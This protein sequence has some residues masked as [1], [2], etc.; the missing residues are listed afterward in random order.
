MGLQDAWKIRHLDDEPLYCEAPHDEADILYAGS[1]DEH[2]DSPDARKLRIEQA[3][4][5]FLQGH[6][7]VLLTTVLRGPFEGPDSKGWVNP[8]QSRKRK[9]PAAST[10][11]PSPAPVPE[12]TTDFELPSTEALETRSTTSCHLPSPRSLDQ[13]DVTP[14]AFLEDEE[15]E[16]V[17]SWRSNTQS[18]SNIQDEAW[19]FDA[20]LS[21][22][23]RQHRRKRR[24]AGSEWLKRDDKKRRKTNDDA[25]NTR[26]ALVPVRRSTRSPRRHLSDSK[27]QSQQN[28]EDDIAEDDTASLEGSEIGSELPLKALQAVSTRIS[29]KM[30]PHVIDKRVDASQEMPAPLSTPV[31]T[32]QSSRKSKMTPKNTTKES[33]PR[34]SNMS[35]IHQKVGGDVEVKS[36]FETQQDES[37]MF[38]A[39]PRSHALNIED[40]SPIR[41]MSFGRASSPASTVSSEMDSHCEIMDL[42]GDTCMADDTKATS[43]ESSAESKGDHEEALENDAE[44]ATEHEPESGLQTDESQP[45]VSGESSVP[46]LVANASNAAAPTDVEEPQN[47]ER[48]K[49]EFVVEP[50]ID[51]SS[52]ESAVVSHSASLE[53][54][55]KDSTNAIGRIPLSSISTNQHLQLAQPITQPQAPHDNAISMTFSQS[56]WSKLSQVTTNSPCSVSKTGEA[57]QQSGNVESCLRRGSVSQ[58]TPATSPTAGDPTTSTTEHEPSYQHKDTPLRSQD[59][60]RV[61]EILS[62]HD[63]PAVPTSQQTPWKMDMPAMSPLKHPQP[64]PEDDDQSFL[65]PECQSPWAPSLEM[66]SKAAPE[67]VKSAFFNAARPVS[68]SSLSPS[69]FTIPFTPADK[70]VSEAQQP[71]DAEAATSSSPEPIFPIKSFKNFMSPSPER[72]RRRPNMISLS[73]GNLPSTQNLIAATTDNPWHSVPKSSKRVRWAPLLHEDDG[74]EG[75]CPQ[76]PTGPKASS[77]P[78]E[79][80]VVDLP[81]G[82][83]DQFQRHFRVVSQRKNLRHHLLPSASQ[84]MLKSPSPMAMA[85]AFVA[86]DS[87]RAPQGPDAVVSVDTTPVT[88]N[89]ESQESAMDDVDDV[90]RNLN[91]FIEMVDIETDLARAKDEEQENKRRRQQQSQS[92]RGA[93]AN[94]LNLDGMMDA[95]VWN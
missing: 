76:T 92:L 41:R 85:E 90:L 89:A 93:F 75:G 60:L 8:W 38:R 21:Q 94:G 28:Q 95:G 42:D 19:S 56:P 86:A 44:A 61:E 88:N 45:E 20:S 70:R 69:I 65:R 34:S 43:P 12:P 82:N 11:G 64:L 87:F 13:V 27:S 50:V 37:F 53:E 91:E 29:H 39:R 73:D 23:Q 66:M 33:G 48:T 16:R 1:D 63:S 7:P 40:L 72:P 14:H 77:P 6:T 55:D 58:A 67:I 80:A 35:M 25:H 52:Q 84:Q 54:Q 24:P 81:T 47:T 26:S 5:R 9:A 79:M 51:R 31:Q 71:F 17:E 74:E 30:S 2:Y 32:P 10:P 78:P 59:Y 15:V 57:H 18:A 36:E 83:K 22:S 46:A 3:A 4:I 49:Q 62:Q 68:P